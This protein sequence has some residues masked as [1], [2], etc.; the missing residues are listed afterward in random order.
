VAKQVE[1]I[2][3]R[4]V[5]EGFE[6]LDKIKGSFRELGKVTNLAEK[7]ILSARDSLL[8]FAKKAGNTEAVNK[9]L[10]DAFK[11]LRSQVDLSSEAYRSLSAELR[12][13][14]EESKG[15]TRS[16]MAQRDA[17]L[18]STAAG[19]QNVAALQQQRAALI[20]LR[21]QTRDSSTAFN[22]FSADIEAVETRLTD[23]IKVN[24]RLNTVL[25]RARSGTS[26]G[27]RAELAAV[28]DGIAAIRQEIEA[29]DLLNK[30]TRESATTQ[31]Q[32]LAIEERLNSALVARR[33]IQF[34][35]KARTGR[36]NVRTDAATF[37]SRD[38]TQGPLS[39]QNISR[40]LGDLPNTTAGLSQELGELNE[41]LIN[42]YRNTETYLQ[43]AM[44]MA[45]VQR[46]LTTVTRGYAQSLVM[47][48]KTN[49]VESSARNLQEAITALRAEMAQL[50]TTTSEGSRAYADNAREANTLDRRLR[51]LADAY[52]E[53]G[54]MATVAATAEQ[55]AA[56][57][58]IRNNYLG[59]G[60]VL[61]QEQALRELGN[62]VQQGV[63]ATPLLLPAAGQTSAPGT[64][65]AISGGP[66]VTPGT[67]ASRTIRDSKTVRMLGYGP[68]QEAGVERFFSSTEPGR[69][70][71]S[72]PIGPTATPGQAAQ[73]R[74]EQ[75]AQRDALKATADA[76]RAAEQQMQRLR[77]AVDTATKANTGS[78]SSLSRLRE[79]LVNL[80][81]EIPG[82]EKEFR[83]LNQQVG[84]V[85]RRAS[86]LQTSRR[87]STGQLVQAGGAAISGGIFGG[88]EGFLGGVGG[89]VLGTALP[90]IGTAGGAFAGAAIG[91][92]VAGL[93]Q[94][95]ASAAAYAAEIR[96][97]QL[98]L[99]GIVS[100]FDDYKAALAAVESTS[101]TFNVPIRE[102]TQQFTKLSAAVL[103]SGGTIKD[104][105]NTF[106]GLTAS[107][108]ATGGSVEDVN[109]ALVAA[110]QVFSK[111]KVTAEELRGQIGERLA[112]AF[113]LFAESSGRS[114][115]GL[116]AALKSG[117][118]TI[119]D[120]VKFTEFSLAKYGRTAQI[121]AASPEQAGARLDRAL[122]KLQQNVG[123]S[124]G[125]AG[126]AFQDFAARSVRGLD[127][128]I[129]KLIELK[130]IQPGAGYYQ[131]QVLE[132]SLSIPQLEDKLLRAGQ[133]E[134]A[135]RQGAAS[136]GLGFIADLLPD[137][138]A[139]TKEA[140][141]LEEALIKVRIIEKET[142]KQRKERKVEEDAT[143]KERLG[144]SLL[145][146]IEQ[147]E[148][149]LLNLRTRREEQL[150]QIR[151][152]AVEQAKQIE[153]QLADKRLAIERQIQDITQQRSDSAEDSARRIREARGEDSDL[154]AAEQKVVDIFREERDSRIQSERTLADD[155]KQQEET[156]AEFQ[157]G[158]AK[159]INDANRAH[160]KSM[161]EIQ[162]QYATSVAKIIDEGTGKAGK[163]LAA[164]AQLA[165][166]YIQR[167]TLNNQI[168]SITGGVIPERRQ[169]V[170]DF[171]TVGGK[172]A[173][174]AATVQNTAEFNDVQGPLKTLL[175]LDETIE[176]LKKGLNLSR[177]PAPGALLSSHSTGIGDQFIALLGAE[178]GYEDVAMTRGQA[179]LIIKKLETE[180]LK[181][182]ISADA[183]T[184]ALNYIGDFANSADASRR[185]IRNLM[186]TP[187]AGIA[188]RSPGLLRN[189]ATRQLSQNKADVKASGV[190]PAS[191]T[192]QIEPMLA[193]I[194]Q[195]QKDNLLRKNVTLSETKEQIQKPLYGA[196]MDWVKANL[197]NTQ[198]Q[199][200]LKT[201]LF[202]QSNTAY[203]TKGILPQAAGFEPA[204]FGVKL[205]P[206][207]L[208]EQQEYEA[209]MRYEASPAGKAEK[210]AAEEYARKFREIIKRMG[211]RSDADVP[212]AFDVSS[213]ATDFGQIASAS[214][215]SGL[216][217]QNSGAPRPYQAGDTSPGPPAARRT[218]E[219]QILRD[220]QGRPLN[221]GIPSAAETTQLRN[222]QAAQ[223][224]LNRQAT[225]AEKIKEAFADV[226]RE[227]AQFTNGLNDQLQ[228]LEDQRKYLD[229]GFSDA[230]S[231]DLANIDQSLTNSQATLRRITDQLKVQG[232][233]PAEAEA[234]YTAEKANLQKVYDINV[235]LTQELEKQAQAMRTRQD[236]RIGL[237]MQEGA[238]AYV[239]SIG[240]MRDATKDLTLNGIKGVE[241]A[242]FDLV[243]T[244]K[245]NFREF[246]A[247]IL[248]QTARMIIQQ[249]VL[250][251]VMQ[252]I[253]AVAPG[254]G[255]FGK[256][257]FD[258][259]TGKG[260]AG[261]NFGF[262][263]GGAFAKNNIVPYAMGGVVTKP[264]LFKFAQG[265]AMRTGLM[266]EAGPE[267][268]MPLSRGPNG[269]LGVSG[270]GGG[271]TNVT[272]NVDASGSKAQ[273]DSGKSEQLGRAVSQAVQ[274]ELL[275]Q[276]RPG[277]LLA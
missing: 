112:G 154:I 13:L 93:R 116:D 198:L 176:S 54:S 16:I 237:G 36:E 160:T 170:Y 197:N 210:A 203:G 228:L 80:R 144:A 201:S 168:A 265:G 254:G 212:G 174:T 125:P 136:A 120:F 217:A 239:E 59:R 213:L 164:A 79:A 62:R 238:Q 38:L 97:L 244:G 66:N 81:N 202:G 200:I 121:I 7:D 96:R 12:R 47:G 6:A 75:I 247:D 30:K 227:G 186:A 89:A 58:R 175:K 92:Q 245:T 184:T 109:G 133:Q 3:V 255:S 181:R 98:A 14:D 101:S 130:A 240:T 122:K 146:A 140:R 1:D 264:T 251:S 90:G 149:A 45:G 10:T 270:S 206:A 72:R 21:A 99:Q 142:N 162:K 169:G 236:D 195:L 152:Q 148:E 257:Y 46:E 274:Q 219:S 104:A 124:L 2:V 223:E 221:L 41:R 226:N 165:A 91:A 55:N 115:K 208:R 102:A 229:M 135:L 78:V 267:A 22:Q 35:E 259:I 185:A 189:L 85:D 40:R 177:T 114:T 82:T 214:F 76:A 67:R 249:L 77:A 277:G 172:G 218:P 211:P 258:P 88:P 61:Q 19:T 71:S 106:K 260:A 4:L 64:G 56:N 242:I 51:N 199:E 53:V 150:A 105:E 5:G 86:R 48:L 134:A 243:T 157:R 8:D 272:V 43:V 256:G 224:G 25:S 231:R 18:S 261:P 74:S 234:A 250:R 246:A 194:S 207:A 233:D 83:D 33:Q 161:G 123:D 193:I 87:P 204:S 268:I 110:A 111:G 216:L 49:T 153:T 187:G 24:S 196:L 23:L 15:A 159:S 34:Q 31:Q 275:R 156:I 129:N 131:Q 192:K 69:F 271:T 220:A 235:K 241:N 155:K 84:G 139:A 273:G 126:A 167:G 70:A 179:T 183:F 230:L 253:G 171:R 127:R 68:D 178:G 39:A 158:V 151:E 215:I 141:I 182:N 9:G 103:G 180:A 276:K 52:R 225:T 209:R 44:Q 42:T 222:D 138:S 50:D 29:I 137:I 145:Q 94:A 63:A 37:N 26:A 28:N 190:N 205:T 143:D 163:R 113:A 108:L 117:E 262:A 27:A 20:A 95:G 252:I 118:V 57:A 263:M 191:L 132:G 119:A 107:V 248:K 100:S 232:V 73:N 17:V 269:K 128:L 266:G 65:Q 11:G 60:A 166:L 173:G 147:R 188:V 32:R